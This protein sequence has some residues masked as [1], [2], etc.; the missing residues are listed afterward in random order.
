MTAPPG[1][2]CCRTVELA[3]RVLPAEHRARYGL[4]F[5]AELYGVPK[6]QQRRHSARVLTSAWA[7][8]TA[9]SEPVPGANGDRAMIV[10]TAKPLTPAESAPPLAVGEHGGRRP[11]RA[12]PVSAS[13][14]LPSRR[15]GS[16]HGLPGPRCHGSG[17][18]APRYRHRDR[19]R[20]PA[21]ASAGR[22][23]RRAA[24]AFWRVLIHLMSK[25][26]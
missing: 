23:R 2:L 9:L 25:R 17:R 8:R 11:L 22:R 20:Q 13:A 12:M 7:V 16:A 18:A 5:I 4:E 15:S 10:K 24:D 1:S 3:V 19:G 21:A 26:H 14:R 6:A